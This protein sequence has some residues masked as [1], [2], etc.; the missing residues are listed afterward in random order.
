[1]DLVIFV[2][3]QAAGKTRFYRE[4]LAGTHAHLGMDL[5][6]S[7]RRPRDR[8]MRELGAALAAGWDLVVDNT[9]PTQADRTP[10]VAIGRRFGATIRA[11]FFETS[12]ADAFER[13]A[14]RT[15]GAFVPEVAIR[16][17]A[18][19]M[20]RPTLDEGFDEVAVVRLAQTGFLHVGTQRRGAPPSPHA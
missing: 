6:R 15:G 8:L 12:I 5:W 1:M 9:S 3:L 19:R 16:A 4:N 11:I 18:A 2:G 13:N 17:T 14:V 20:E 10:I 7:A